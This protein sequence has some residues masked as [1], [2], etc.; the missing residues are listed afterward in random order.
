MIRPIRGKNFLCRGASRI[1][2]F[3]CHRIKPTTKAVTTLLKLTAVMTST[4]W[5]NAN[6][7]A[8][9][10]APIMKATNSKVANAVMDKALDFSV[11]DSLCRIESVHAGMQATQSQQ[12]IGVRRT[13][14]CDLAQL[15]HNTD[16]GIELHCF[17][18]LDVLHHRCFERA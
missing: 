7:A 3:C 18:S 14:L 13:D 1:C 10:L 9:W 4:P 15:A 11:M 2:T 8:T 16:Q 5:L 6:R 12:G 17:T